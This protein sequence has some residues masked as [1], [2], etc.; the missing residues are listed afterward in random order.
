MTKPSDEWGTPAYIFDPLNKEFGFNLDVCATATNT[1]VPL[2]YSLELDSV[3]RPWAPMTCWCNPPYSNPMPLIKK[4]Y[5]EAEKGATVVMLLR[6]DPS[7]RWWAIFWDH[8]KH[9]PRRPN[10]E[11]RYIFKRVKF[12]GAKGSY[13]FP[14]A[15]VVLRPATSALS[16]EQSSRS[17]IT[18]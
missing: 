8:E 13:D 11:V 18:L 1:K 9:R 4:A 5:S 7:T 3:Q 17:T 12:V 15:V 14:S 16:V 10:D 6:S 2:F